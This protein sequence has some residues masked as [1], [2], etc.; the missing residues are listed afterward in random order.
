MIAL[1]LAKGEKTMIAAVV[2]AIGIAI[3]GV[4]GT[5]FRGKISDKLVNALMTA[6]GLVIVVIGV[7]GA[8]GS[9]DTLCVVI[10]LAIGA[11]TGEL[12][13]IDRFLDGIGDR[14]QNK[15]KGKKF[16]EGH[17]AEGLI[18]ASVLFTVG[19]MAILGSIEAG[20]NNNYSVLFTKTVIDAISAVALASALGIGVMFSLI[21][22]LVWEGLLVLL[23][24]VVS[25]ILG[26]EVITELSAVGGAMFIGMGINMTGIADRKI[27]ISN[28][29]PSLAV[30]IIY[31][32]VSS[33]LGGLF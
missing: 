30:P 16:A 25:P 23:A 32:P 7:Q 17:F 5:L 9:N 21:P 26:T 31:I 28:L 22:V 8:A 27:N 29:I 11:I 33:W 6:M 19:A 15:L 2:N 18:T 20:I 13:H 1:L 14:V 4:L 12:L 24:G 3:G 10:S